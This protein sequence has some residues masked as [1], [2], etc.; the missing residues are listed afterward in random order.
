MRKYVGVAPVVVLVMGA[1][2]L[3]MGRAAPAV[4]G[5]AN[6]AVEKVAD[7]VNNPAQLKKQAADLASNFEL[8]DVAWT[9]KPREKGGLGVGKT[10]GAIDPDAIELQ[11]LRI[12][13]TKKPVPA[14]DLKT[15]KADYQRMA[16][17]VRGIAEA[18][19]GFVT[20]YTKNAKEAKQWVGFADDMQQGS[21]DLI[22]AI[23]GNNLQAIKLAAG[24]LNLSCNGCHTVFRD[25]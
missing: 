14:D 4:P 10:P 8:Q 20:K 11:L 2:L 13:N 16:E 17:V 19:P 5:A 24:K 12:G 15:N 22:A 21:S 23:K 25:N 3:D 18:M 6:A 1:W 7:A 9:L